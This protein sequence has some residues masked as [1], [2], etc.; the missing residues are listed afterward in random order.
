M[1]T[2][3]ALGGRPDP[4]APAIA[5]EVN[6]HILALEA[7][8]TDERFLARDPRKHLIGF[9][10]ECGCLGIV[11]V[12]RDAYETNRGAWLEGHRSQAAA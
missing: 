7:R 12:T 6:R 10:C 5:R 8:L 3:P 2:E 4:D 11:A 9:F 1:A